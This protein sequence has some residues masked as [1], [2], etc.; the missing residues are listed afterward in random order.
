MI[1]MLFLFSGLLI[2]MIGSGYYTLFP[3]NKSLIFKIFLI[4]L[5]PLGLGRGYLMQRPGGMLGS[6][7]SHE[8]QLY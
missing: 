4:I 8:G 1:F 6:V 5:L 2:F 3:A 7:L